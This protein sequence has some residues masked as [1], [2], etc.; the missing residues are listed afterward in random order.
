MP[1]GCHTFCSGYENRQTHGRETVAGEAG[2]PTFA[3]CPKAAPASVPEGWKCLAGIAPSTE[4]SPAPRAALTQHGG[5]HRPAW[6]E[7]NHDLG[8]QRESN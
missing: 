7:L 3:I 6:A 4:K 1:Q 8:K 5:I 2:A